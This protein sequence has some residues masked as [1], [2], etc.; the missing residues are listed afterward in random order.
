MCLRTSCIPRCC[1]LLLASP[2]SG[3]IFAQALYTTDT[4]EIY[5]TLAG[6][7]ITSTLS[8]DRTNTRIHVDTNV[9][10]QST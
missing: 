1:P 7:E 10:G 8:V 5:L 4:C 9:Q 6:C 2:S 3:T